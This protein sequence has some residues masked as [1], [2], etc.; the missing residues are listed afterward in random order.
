MRVK[1]FPPLP[2]A[3][4]CLLNSVLSFT[5]VSGHGIQLADEPT[6]GCGVKLGELV[7][8][9]LRYRLLS[10]R[11]TV[12]RRRPNH[13]RLACRSM[14]DRLMN[15]NWLLPEEQLTS[16]H[17]R[18]GPSS[19]EQAQAKEHPEDRNGDGQIHAG[20]RPDPSGSDRR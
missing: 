4:K 20:V 8:A 12:L 7:G 1:F 3:H 13:R 2:G 17:R 18:A 14:A 5:V 15:G 11:V 16:F 9:H 19:K 10:R 6:E